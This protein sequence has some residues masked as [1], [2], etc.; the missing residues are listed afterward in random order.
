MRSSIGILAFIGFGAVSVAFAD[1]SAT[2][3]ATTATAAPAAQATATAPAQP[4]APATSATPAAP[5]VAAPAAST[6]AA[7]EERERHFLSEG[8]RL[9]M[10]NGEKVFCR[11]EE[12]LGSRLG[13]Q[14]VCAS[15]LQLT[16]TERQAKASMDGSVM[17][18]SN[19]TGK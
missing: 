18:H 15:A 4:A 10:R 19:P 16:E 9:E 12:M 3:T 13:A 17:Q 1:P 8:Y 2:E 11:R 5:K 7:E 14:K 6:S